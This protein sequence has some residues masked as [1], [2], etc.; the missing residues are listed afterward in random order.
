MAVFR[1]TDSLPA[2]ARGCVVAIGNFDGVH[3]GHRSVL[4][5]A[6]E[7]ATALGT[8]PAI[9]TFEPHPRQV[10]Q[11]DAPPFRLSSLRTK[12]RLLEAAGMA[13]LFVR[14]FDSAFSKIT[15]E[16]FVTEILLD[17][18]AARHVVIGADFRF[19]HRRR[20]DAA[21]LQALAAPAGVEVSALPPVLDDRGEVVSSSRIRAA[22]G[23][24][25]VATA[26][27][28]L[29]RPWELEGRVEPGAQRGRTIG[30]PTAN[31]RLGDYLEPRHGIYAVRAGVD[32]G[33]ETAWWDG[34][35]YV[36]RRPVVA[37]AD[38]LLEVFVFDASPELYGQHLRVQ[39]IGFVRAD[40]PFDGLEA[41]KMQIDADCAAARAILARTPDPGATST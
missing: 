31:L 33:V 14:H 3:R 1:H 38:V 25:D 29:G 37:G 5:E 2:E 26:T 27:A 20:G 16:S 15:A 12:V 17:Q 22:L 8:R 18:L 36:G 13:Q 4:A 23:A 7:R 28:L 34:V 41:L 35:A 39:V 6:R 19:G 9:L 30:F 24:G 10:F 32:R 21:C 11:P 40:A